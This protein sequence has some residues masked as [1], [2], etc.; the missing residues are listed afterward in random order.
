MHSVLAAVSTVLWT[1]S[2]GHNLDLGLE[3]ELQMNS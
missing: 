2:E 1:H 3:E